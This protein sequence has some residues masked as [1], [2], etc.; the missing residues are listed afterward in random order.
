VSEVMLKLERPLFGVVTPEKKTQKLSQGI[1][2]NPK[3]ELTVSRYEVGF[4]LPAPNPWFAFE[5]NFSK[6]KGDICLR[7]GRTLHHVCHDL[8]TYGFLGFIRHIKDNW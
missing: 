5:F 3:I 7:F 4:Y 8:R 1:L 6:K 2:Y